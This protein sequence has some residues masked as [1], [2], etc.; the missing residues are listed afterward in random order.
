MSYATLLR[1]LVH[2]ADGLGTGDAG[3]LFGALLDGGVPEM[4][5]GATLMALAVR[6]ETDSEWAGF[7]RAL[8]ARQ[9]FLRWPVS[10]ATRPLV[11]P[12]YCG[13][14]DQFNL[15]PL[16]VLL[17]VKF[18]IPVL[19][20]GSLESQ[21]R[22]T[23]AHVLREL[24][25]LPCASLTQANEALSRDG[26]A[27]VPTAV[28][29]PGLAHLL[30][31]HARIGVRGTAHEL[32]KLLAPFR[33]DALRVIGVQD[34]AQLDRMRRRLA[35]SSAHALLLVGTEGEA[36]ANSH[37]RPRLWHCSRG[38]CQM[39][40]EAEVG[41][42]QVPLHLPVGQ[43]VTAIADWIRE[44]LAGHHALPMP[45]L[46]QIACCLYGTGRCPDMNQAKATVA[47]EI[48]H[49]TAV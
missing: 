14:R 7:V 10:G 43:S 26:L 1:H 29:A 31:Q 34:E 13:T 39:L 18:G 42:E 36:I 44:S 8:E 35:D 32:V 30:A 2:E 6:G 5:M 46:N 15:V 38:V 37:R 20:H 27:F 33:G 25:I 41:S 45:M 49:L 48:A 47:M 16:F 9:H 4:E 19:V 21:G 28:I 22:M 3:Q 40:F 11:I 12:S 24:G 17:L 23:T